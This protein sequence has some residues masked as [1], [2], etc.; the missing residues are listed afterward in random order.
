MM[1][2]KTIV[3]TTRFY[4]IVYILPRVF[5]YFRIVQEIP[6][7]GRFL[8]HKSIISQDSVSQL[9]VDCGGVA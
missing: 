6:T 4:R 2:T 3:S 9:Y 8:I 7:R 5:V 1:P